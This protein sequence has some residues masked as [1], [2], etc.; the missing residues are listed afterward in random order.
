MPDI[1]EARLSALIATLDPK[2]RRQLAKEIAKNLRDSQARRIAAQQNPDG[3]PYEPRKPRLRKKQ[4][5]LRK[6]MFAK[7]RTAKY[8]KTEATPEAATVTFTAQAQRIARIHQFGLRDRIGALTVKYP[9]R[10][11]LGFTGE[12]TDMVEQKV[13][14]H[15]SHHSP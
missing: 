9:E 14:D 1:L 5:T 10:R 6:T 15:L 8:L 7:L 2:E 4:G 3:S 13:M 11:L 12:E